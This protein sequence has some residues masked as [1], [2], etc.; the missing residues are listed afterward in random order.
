MHTLTEIIAEQPFFAGLDLRWIQPLTDHATNVLYERDTY[1][2]KEGEQAERLYI[3]REGKIAGLPAT[4]AAAQ[5][6][7][8][9]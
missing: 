4:R 8:T 5:Q 9:H 1:I 3:L 7:E 2:F 6:P